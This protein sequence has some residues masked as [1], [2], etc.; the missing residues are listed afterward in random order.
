MSAHIEI[1]YIN[2]DPAGKD[3]KCKLNDEWVCIKNVGDSSV[4]LSSWILTDWRP[5]QKHIHKYTL[6]T[7]INFYSTWTLSPDELLFIMTGSGTD[8]YFEK[9][10]KYSAQFHLYQNRSQFIW[11]NTGDTACLYDTSGN[12]VSTL[13]V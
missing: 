12:L 8:K 13:T 4:D 5:E 10:D 3:T 7:Y 11:N 2:N 1:T 9:T 6:P